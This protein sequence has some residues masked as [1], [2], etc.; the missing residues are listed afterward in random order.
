MKQ[1]IKKHLKILW[2][3]SILCLTGV[4][5]LDIANFSFPKVKSAIAAEKK[6]H[7]SERK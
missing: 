3:L 6:Y 1:A 2:I 5:I 4:A 7:S